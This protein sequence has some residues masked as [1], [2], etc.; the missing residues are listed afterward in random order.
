MA[1]FTKG[2]GQHIQGAL[3][4]GHGVTFYRPAPTLGKSANVTIYCLLKEIEAWRRRHSNQFPET[5]YVQIDGGG[6]NANKSLHAFCEFLVAK[7]MVKTV[8]LTRYMLIEDT[9]VLYMNSV[10]MCRSDTL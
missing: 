7:R 9:P 4:H 6:D 10:S 1:A 8:V 5:L 2:L 3:V